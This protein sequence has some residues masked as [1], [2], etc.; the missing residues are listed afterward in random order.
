MR[1]FR[2]ALVILLLSIL[3][4]GILISKEKE[5]L[6]LDVDKI[7]RYKEDRIVYQRIERP[8]VQ[9]QDNSV[10]ILLV[11]K[12]S[13][14]YFIADGFDKVDEVKMKRIVMDAENKY[15]DNN[16]FWLN[17]I[18]GKPD[19][20]RII[21]RR[22]DLLR[23]INEEFVSSNFGQF[24]KSVRDGF[25]KMHVEKFRTL[26]KNRGESGLHVR[27]KQ[28]SMEVNP[29]NS[30]DV[31]QKFFTSATGKSGD[32]VV[33]YCEDADGDGITETFMAYRNDGFDWGIGSGP[34][35]LMIYGNTDKDIETLIGKLVN[36]SENGTVE[37]EKK[38]FQEFPQEGDILKMIEDITPLDRFYE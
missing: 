25:I 19:C 20:V 11:I 28:I 9:T 24:Y 36:E 23:N 4:S 35:I 27:K 2:Y 7:T 15:V 32:E 16:D 22:S 3:C 34:N 29:D 6:I 37:E 5:Y 33:Y 38:M 13:K 18:N 26:M 21:Y 12:D 31:K 30:N 8:D 17:K 1:K 14:S 10:E